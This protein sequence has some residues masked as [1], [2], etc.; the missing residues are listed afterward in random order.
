MTLKDIHSPTCS[1]ANANQCDGSDTVNAKTSGNRALYRTLWRWHFYAGLFCIPF[2]IFLSVS[3]AIFLFKPQIEHWQDKKQNALSHHQPIANASQQIQTA[4]SALPNS[5]FVSYRLPRTKSHAA[6]IALKQ[7]E[8]QYAL[9]VHPSELTVLKT[10]NIDTSFLQLVRTFHGELLVGNAGSILVEL[11]SC[12]AI[13]LILTGLYLWW[14]RNRKGLGG[15]LYPRVNKGIKILLRDGHA[16]VGFWVAFFTLFLLVSG[17]PWA[18]VWGSAFKEVRQ[19]VAAPPVSTTPFTLPQTRASLSEH[20]GHSNTQ[21]TQ[22]W[23]VSRQQPSWMAQA[24]AHVNL[25]QAVI[26]AAKQQRLAHPVELSIADSNLNQWK[27]ASRHQNRPLRSTVW[28]DESG[29]LIKREDFSQKSFIDRA[30]GIGIAAHEGQLFGWLNQ[31][32]GVLTAL[33]LITLSVTGF[34]MWRKRKPSTELGAP[35]VHTHDK[36]A[37]VF[38]GTMI[39]AVFLPLLAISMVVILVIEKGLLRFSPKAQQWLGVK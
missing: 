39:L 26:D 18:L 9:F 20:A 22:D 11:A 23:T 12:W 38:T 3:G 28:L 25:P 17:L 10:V 1:G 30:V 32:L 14:P 37:V 33:G 6:V 21:T 13:V 4:Q 7:S 27:A 19:W 8:T 15:V 29:K 16:V 34:L 5:K 35:P 31:L 36:G 2:I 24:V